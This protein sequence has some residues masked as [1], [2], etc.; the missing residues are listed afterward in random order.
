VYMVILGC[1]IYRVSCLF[2]YHVKDL[3]KSGGGGVF[4]VLILLSIR[5]L[6]PFILFFLK[7]MVARVLIR[8][9]GCSLAIVLLA[10]SL[11]RLGYYLRVRVEGYVFSAD[12]KI[13]RRAGPL[14]PRLFLLFVLWNFFVAYYCFIL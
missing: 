9:C 8:T 1:T 13:G 2:L 3:G 11:L 5:G 10:S 14:V 7:V 4:L 6:P 12:W